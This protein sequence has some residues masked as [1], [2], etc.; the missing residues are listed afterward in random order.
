MG[1]LANEVWRAILFCLN[2][3]L[4]HARSSRCSLRV[5]R[6]SAVSQRNCSCFNSLALN[7]ASGLCCCRICKILKDIFASTPSLFSTLLLDIAFATSRSHLPAM[8]TWIHKHIGALDTIAA[9][10]GGP[11]LDTLLGNLVSYNTLNDIS[12]V[13]TQAYLCCMWPATVEV[14]SYFTSLKE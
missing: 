1:R 4:K 11:W 12:T 14:L 13:V 10:R 5:L 2:R 6:C 9:H 7:F 3:D 8:V